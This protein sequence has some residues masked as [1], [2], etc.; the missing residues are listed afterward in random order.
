[1]AMFGLSIQLREGTM[2]DIKVD[3]R[4]HFATYRQVIRPH[5]ADEAADLITSLYRALRIQKFTGPVTINM[6]QG[7]IRDIVTEQITRVPLGSEADL[8][9]EKAFG[10]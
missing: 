10:K 5:A 7:G 1:M 9:L 8:V 4:E 6:N 2:N 3:R